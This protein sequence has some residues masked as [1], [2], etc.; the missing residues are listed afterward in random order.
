MA[1]K[2]KIITGF[3][4]MWPRE[5]LD[6]RAEDGKR[7]LRLKSTVDALQSPGVYV[8]Y[9][10]DHPYYIGQATRLFDRIHTHAN[11]TTDRYF[12][13]WNF[14]SAFLVD[15]EYLN[16]VETILIAAMPTANRSKPRV[17]SKIRIPKDMST[18]LRRIRRHASEPVTRSDINA[19][20]KEIQ[21][22]KI[23]ASRLK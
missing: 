21:K 3:L 2:T 19:L 11:K 4:S 23:A 10:E 6:I 17:S 7:G 1:A 9:R 5:L 18:E 20:L 13:F 8:L 16:D 14:F 12:N 22:L 15:K